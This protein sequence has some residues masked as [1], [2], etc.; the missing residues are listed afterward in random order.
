MPTGTQAMSVTNAYD[1]N[2]ALLSVKHDQ[3]NVVVWQAQA[4]N[5]RGALSLANLGNG[6]EVR[7]GYDVNGNNTSVSSYQGST[8]YHNALVRLDNVFN[9]KDKRSEYRNT[10]ATYQNFFEEYTYDGLNR[11]KTRTYSATTGTLPVPFTQTRSFDYDSA[12]NLSYKSDKGYYKYQTGK[13][14]QLESIHSAST[15]TTANRLLNFTYDAN[16]NVTADTQRTFT[17]SAFDKPLSIQ[18][19]TNN[20]TMTYGINR[21]MLTKRHQR[22]EAGSQVITDHAYIGNY[23]RIKKTTGNAI[24][25][26]KYTLAGGQVI[27][28]QRSNAT[29]DTHYLH[30]DTQGSIAMVTDQAKNIVTQALYSPFGE[31]MLLSQ[32]SI[33]SGI[34]HQPAT[35]KGYTGHQQVNSVGITHMGGRIYDAS[36]GR[37]LQADPFIQAPMNSQNYN[38]YS[39]VMNNPM[40]YTDPSGYFFSG[41]KKFVKKY[42]KPIVALAATYFTAGAASSWVSTWGTTWG[43]AATATSAATLTTT[44]S[45]AVGAIAGATGGFVG[46]AVMTGSLKGSLVGAFSG[47]LTGAVG[48][49]AKGM[50]DSFFAKGMAGGINGAME[51]GDVKGFIRGFAAGQINNSLGIDAYYDN[52]FANFAINRVADYAKDY[53]IGGKDVA[54]KNLKYGLVNDGIGHGIGLTTSYIEHGQFKAPSFRDG[55]YFYDSEQTIKSL[56][57]TAMVFGNVATGPSSMHTGQLS[58]KSWLYQH[59]RGHAYQQRS[60]GAFYAPMHMFSQWGNH[61]F[62]SSPFMEHNPLITLGY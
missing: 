62:G 9:V 54:S 27:I 57:A 55:M 5:S 42:W 19:G 43:T 26:H 4:F 51:S 24:T 22:T 34:I 61:L 15:L 14:N 37:F 46:G 18:Q 39:Y 20:I 40:T 38:R 53:V 25:E 58:S 56:G 28:T 3:S 31:Q 59:E 23:E 35:E 29:T 44:G 41:L 10:N 8:L 52:Q 32:A 48:G 36:I 50:S 17:Y 12:G 2:G 7:Y 6:L 30:K 13:A 21:Q 45:M 47:A 49:Y 11:L 16:G 1:I 60:L 33:L